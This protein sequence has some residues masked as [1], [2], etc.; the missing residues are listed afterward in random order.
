MIRVWKFTLFFL[1]CLMVALVLNLP[2][3]QVMA[4]VKLPANI[5]VSEID[6]SLLR[7]RAAEVVINRFPLR[8]IRYHYQASC[9]LRLKV[10]Y[11]LDY[12]RGRVNAAYDIVNGDSEVF[13]ARIDYPVSELMAHV[14]NPLV[15]PAG[16]VEIL[17]DEISLTNGKPNSVNGRLVWRDL[18]L[19]DTGIKVN[20]G[21]YQIDFS[22]TPEQYDFEISDLDASL[23]IEGDGSINP[24]GVYKL[25]I[26]IES[27]T[28]IDSNVKTVLELVAKNVGY[29]KYRV[30]KTGRLPPQMRNQLF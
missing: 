5:Q 20:I 13:E 17:V 4:F 29:N 18:G 30:Q 28:G 27:E 15:Q 11:Q 19:D 8:D 21:D 1:L 22:G 24:A 26:A 25:D 14:P 2:I 7:G 12:D 3:Q 16:K 6:G 10:C 23:D 9:L